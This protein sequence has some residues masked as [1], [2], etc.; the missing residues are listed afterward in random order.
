[1]IHPLQMYISVVFSIF[2]VIQPS[3]KSILEHFHHPKKE[4]PCV[5][6]VTP[7]SPPISASLPRQL[8]I[9]FKSLTEICLFLTFRINIV[10]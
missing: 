6:P 9:Y 3:P 10:I 7:H 4:I 8:P 5:L 2:T 1:M